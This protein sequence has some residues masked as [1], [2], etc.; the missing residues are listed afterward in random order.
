MKRIR[1]LLPLLLLLGLV[2]A[3]ASTRG[4]RPQ[5]TATHVIRLETL[6]FSEKDFNRGVLGEPLDIELRILKDGIPVTPAMGA[7]PGHGVMLDGKRGERRV[8]R[9][10]QW[11]LEVGPGSHYQLELV[12]HALIAHKARFA[13]PSAPELGWWFFA[14]HEG[15]VAVG[16]ESWLRF[17]DSI[18]K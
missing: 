13:V 8:Q 18:V 12:E 11:V 1:P 6:Q 14:E 17:S 3:C 9:E 7:T 15:R 16:S 5:K 10:L 2:L 4:A